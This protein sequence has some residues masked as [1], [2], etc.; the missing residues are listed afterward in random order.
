[1]T[2]IAAATFAILIEYLLYNYCFIIQFIHAI[3]FN[4]IYII[5]TNVYT[6]YIIVL[7]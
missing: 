6:I 1:M 7:L 3:Y 5:I 4:R 2:T